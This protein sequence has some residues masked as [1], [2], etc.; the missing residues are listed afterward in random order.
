MKVNNRIIFLLC[1]VVVSSVLFFEKSS[2]N[3]D[4]VFAEYGNIEMKTKY[5]TERIWTH[6]E[7]LTQK[8]PFAHKINVALDNCCSKIYCSS[9]L[10]SKKTYE[11]KVYVMSSK[12]RLLGAREYYV[13]MRGTGNDIGD[14][15]NCFYSNLNG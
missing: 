4:N 11:E 1:F 10:L 5:S 6:K 3:N 14:A 12:E 13:R 9:K 2:A 8:Q 7:F 15:V